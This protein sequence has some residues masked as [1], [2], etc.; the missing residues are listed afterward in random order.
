[1]DQ[2]I[3]LQLHLCLFIDMSLHTVHGSITFLLFCSSH[4]YG[5]RLLRL[6][7]KMNK[8][9]DPVFISNIK[10]YSLIELPEGP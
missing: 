2:K 7:N 5:V 6:R 10:I 3:L 1:M 9:N 8:P 4:N